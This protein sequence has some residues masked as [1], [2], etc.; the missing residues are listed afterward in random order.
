IAS[1]RLVPYRA[2]VILGPADIVKMLA[3]TAQIT[4]TAKS[5]LK[6]AVM[7]LAVILLYTTGLRL[8]ELVRLTLADADALVGV[9]HIRESKFH[10]S[11]FLPLSADAQRELNDYLK[12][13]LAAPFSNAPNSP[14]LCHCTDNSAAIAWKA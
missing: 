3:A 2:P 8:G 4:R 12:L 14:L 5:P 1:P 13:R 6:P 7:R 9:L 10:K 11:R